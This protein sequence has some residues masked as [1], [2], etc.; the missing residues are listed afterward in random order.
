[1]KYFNLILISVLFSSVVSAQTPLTEAVDFTAKDIYGV[2]HHLF[3]ILDNQQ[4]YVLIDFFS[5]TCGPC[6][7]MAPI[8]DSIYHEFGSNELGLNVM[9]IDQ[10]FNNEM[11]LGFEQ[12]YNTHYPAISGIEGGGAGI[13]EDYQIPYYPSLILI[14][15]DHEIVEQAISI[16]E[17]TAELR[18]LLESYGLI[19]IGLNEMEKGPSFEIFPNPAMDVIHVNFIE[20]ESIQKVIVYSVTGKEILLKTITAMPKNSIAVD[21]SFLEKGFYLISIENQKGFRFTKTFIKD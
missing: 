21:I 17:T 6:Q 16:P 5:V 10:T 14:A 9:A 4:Q 15:P 11:V 18:E 1:M 7:D 8:M 2:Q 19:T 12:E 13:Y 3:D 20:K